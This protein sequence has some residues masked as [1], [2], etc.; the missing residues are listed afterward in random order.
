MHPP[1]AVSK[2]CVWSWR[3]EKFNIKMNHM[4]LPIYGEAH[5]GSSW[6]WH[7]VVKTVLLKKLEEEIKKMRMCTIW[8][9]GV[10]KAS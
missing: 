3:G 6:W 2:G 8:L 1:L 10:V 9:A 7:W 5:K 4:Q